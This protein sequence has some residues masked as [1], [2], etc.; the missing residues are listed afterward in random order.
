MEREVLHEA[1]GKPKEVRPSE[2]PL[3]RQEGQ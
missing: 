1:Y 3:Q 2:L